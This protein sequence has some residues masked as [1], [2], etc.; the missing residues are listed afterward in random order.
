MLWLS[1][2]SSSLLGLSGED[3][4]IWFGLF[5]ARLPTCLAVFRFEEESLRLVFKPVLWSASFLEVD[6]SFFPSLL[7]VLE[8]SIFVWLLSVLKTV[9]G[10]FE[11]DW[12]GCRLDRSTFVFENSLVRCLFDSLGRVGSLVKMPETLVLW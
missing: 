5:S 11:V 4:T 1:L 6:R 9:L 7:A 10:G 2:L 12:L 3:L 8:S